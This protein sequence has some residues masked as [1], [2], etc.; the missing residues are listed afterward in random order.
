MLLACWTNLKG[1]VIAAG[2]VRFR[3]RLAQ[4]LLRQAHAILAQV[5]CQVV[6]RQAAAA[7]LVHRRKCPLDPFVP[8]TALLNL[9]HEEQA[10]SPTLAHTMHPDTDLHVHA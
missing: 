7:A 3:Q 1:H 10:V 8:L 5:G 2:A 9:Q 4:R 6:T